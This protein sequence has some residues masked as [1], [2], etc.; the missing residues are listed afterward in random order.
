MEGRDGGYGGM[1][2]RVGMQDMEDRNKIRKLELQ[3]FTNLYDKKPK[4][5]LDIGVDKF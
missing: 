3:R 1:G 4:S 5:S 2:W